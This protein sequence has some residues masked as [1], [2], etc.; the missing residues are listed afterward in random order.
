MV[1]EPGFVATEGVL[2]LGCFDPELLMQPADVAEALLL[3]LRMGPNAV[4]LEVA[5]EVVRSPEK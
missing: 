4:P 1:I 2:Q 3:P 5:M